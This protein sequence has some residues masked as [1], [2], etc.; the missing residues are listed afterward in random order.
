MEKSIPE[1]EARNIILDY[2][3]SNNVLLEWKLKFLR[4]KN[5]NLTR[6]QAEYVLKYHQVVPKVARK[7][8]TL[9]NSYAEKLMEEKQL[10]TLP[11]KIWCEKI[12]CE[13]DKAY[14]IWGKILDT[15]QL[16]S[17]WLPKTSIIPDEKRLKRVVDY[18]PY[19]VRPPMN[20]QKVAI[21]RLLANDR[22]I[23]ADGM[24][25]GKTTSA[26]IASI[27]SQAK[28]I[29]IVCPASLKIN[30]LREI[31][32]YTDRG[33]M[34]VE[35]RKWKDENDFYIINYDI[36]KNF[37]TLEKT[38]LSEEYNI[39]I[40]T[41]FD[42]AI[43]DEAHFLSNN[44]ANRTLLLNDLLNKIP[45]VWLLTGTPITSRPMNYYN[46]LNI[47][48]SPLT[49]NWEHFVRRYCGGYKFRVG[50]K[51]I[52]NTSGASNLDEL[53]EST[54][55]IILRRTKNDVLD[56]PEKIITP[57]FL[58]LESK[59]YN[60]E[61]E[62]FVKITQDK[63]DAD[64]IPVTLSRLMKV[65]QL[66]SFEKIPYT[67]ELIEKC[68]EQ[69]KKVIILT[70]FTMTL[71]LLHEK[72]KKNSVILDGRMTK[73]KKQVSIDR[74]QND[75][76]IKIFIGNIKA[77]GVGI[78]LTAAE[79]VIMNDLSFVPADHAQGEDRCYRYGQKNNVI[80][81]YPIFNNTI[82]LIVYNILEKKKNIIDQVMGDGDYAESFTKELF[83]QLF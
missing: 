3:G 66:I 4:V 79:I 65:R 26:V 61:L 23:L 7:Y 77:A 58:E 72:Y 52:W 8:I 50:K 42:L 75:D 43:I 19:N 37:H 30:W 5:F 34:V 53:R 40:K 29:L 62:E 83:Q 69:D 47:I 10:F 45:K 9:V 32:N 76:K 25:V 27:E 60:E 78:T 38:E 1:I 36:I 14:N 24:G 63:K 15:H 41:N 48:K 80:V 56:L 44:T 68:L 11:T 74:F 73:D 59:S 12:L 57:I 46:L 82:E 22:F 21:E 28:K 67:C 20:H 71:N 16:S 31:K 55:N 35:G 54:K 49:T 33:V 2:E 51:K 13:S 70:N 18:S 17:F 39:L 64:S 81:Y 6:P